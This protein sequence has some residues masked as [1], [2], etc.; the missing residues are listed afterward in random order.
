MK[1]YL[2]LSFLTILLTL[3]LCS[4]HHN[5]GGDMYQIFPIQ[6]ELETPSVIL[7]WNS[8]S[9][10]EKQQYKLVSYVINSQEDFPTDN[11][12]GLEKIKSMNIDFDKY[13]LLLSYNRTDGIVQSHRYTWRKNISEGVFELLINFKVTNFENNGSDDNNNGSSGDNNDNST[14]MEAD[15]VTYSCSALLVNKLPPDFKVNFWFSSSKYL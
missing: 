7:D 2:N 3:I 1:K 11:L 12:L 6:E 9:S 14:S 4:C 8:L 5:E 13:T 10:E 15:F